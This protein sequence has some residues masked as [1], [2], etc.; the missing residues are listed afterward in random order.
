MTHGA[1]ANLVS[2]QVERAPAAEAAA[3]TLQFS[4]LSFD[5]CFQEM[6]STWA[7][8]GTVALIRDDDRRDPDA[9]L[10]ILELERIGRLFLPFVALSQLAEAAGR[11][12]V[13]LPELREVITA[14]EQLQGSEA[15]TG[16]FRRLGGCTLENQYGTSEV[17]VVSGFPLP[18]DPAGWSALPPIGRPI[19]NLR[20]YVLDPEMRPV[21]IGVPGEVFAGGAQ[22][23]LGYIRRPDQTAARFVPDHLGG[24]AGERLYR[25][26]DLARWLPDGNLEFR[27]RI[28]LQVKVRGFRIDLGEIEAALAEHPAV[29][30]VVVTAPE[31]DRVRRLPRSRRSGRR[32][33]RPTWCPATG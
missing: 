14:G 27:G 5:I 26:G 19:R 28:D 6:C 3:R 7:A 31:I 23:A 18:A 21:P 2:F 13:R 29:R 17:H 33:C 30:A 20:L 4:P 25:T 32:G 8:G 1:L 12:G 9:L 15:I 24:A 22:L 16:W 10:E 11:R